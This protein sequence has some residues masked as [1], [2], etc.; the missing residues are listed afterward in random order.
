MSEGVFHRL[1][2]DRCGDKLEREESGYSQIREPS[3]RAGW[4]SIS[5]KTNKEKGVAV[6][7]QIDLC[8]ICSE[9]LEIFFPDKGTPL[10][11]PSMIYGQMDIE[12]AIRYQREHLAKTSGAVGMAPVIGGMGQAVG[13]IGPGAVWSSGDGST[14]QK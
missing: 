13:G 7:K 5:I 4:T 8:P 14:G 1:T 6:G 9:F 12:A 3:E 10:L 11:D 2:C